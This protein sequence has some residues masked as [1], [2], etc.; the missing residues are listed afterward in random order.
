MNRWEIERR[1]QERARLDAWHATERGHRSVTGDYPLGYEWLWRLWTH[2]LWA[3]GALRP[4]PST[5]RV[6]LFVLEATVERVEVRE[7]VVHESSGRY[8][9]NGTTT[10]YNYTQRFQAFRLTLTDGRECDFAVL[11]S[12]GAD[13]GAVYD[14]GRQMSALGGKTVKLAG[15]VLNERLCAWGVQPL[16]GDRPL[17]AAHYPELPPVCLAEAVAR[18]DSSFTVFASLHLLLGVPLFT[19]F[20]AALTGA[21]FSCARIWRL[22]LSIGAA[23]CLPLAVAAA[24]QIARVVGRLFDRPLLPVLDQVP[25]RLYALKTRFSS[26]DRRRANAWLI[27]QFQLEPVPESPRLVTALYSEHAWAMLAVIAVLLALPALLV[28][29]V[30]CLF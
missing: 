25:D 8:E 11:G 13:M 26:Y 3:L 20:F 17:L 29:N 24:W 10:E 23:L 30:Y 18:R 1:N 15:Y 6:E 4:L 7:P 19:F 2:C 16:G 9:A 28:R 22:D 14:Y 27:E 5:S 21:N 12:I